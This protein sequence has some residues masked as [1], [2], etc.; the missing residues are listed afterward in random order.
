[1]TDYNSIVSN[2][3]LPWLKLD[4]TFNHKAMLEEAKAIK[5]L[6]VAHRDQ[7]QGSYRHKGWRSICIHGISAEKTNHYT[8]YGYE[9]NE[10]TPYKWTDIANLCPI[11]TNFFKE[12]FPFD[13]YYRVRFMLLDPQ[14]YITPHTDTDEHKLSPVNI[15]LNNPIGCNFKMKEHNGYVPFVPGSAFLL[16]VGNTHAVFN[17]SSE[18]RYHMIVHGKPNKKFKEL[19]EISYEKNGIK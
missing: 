7:D 8:Q 13:E 3:G 2:S 14:G 5:H 17:N 19:V 12:V 4:L 9:S 16:D 10:V 18:D 6:F 11:T 1:M 15:A